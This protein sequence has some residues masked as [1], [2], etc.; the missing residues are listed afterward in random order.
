MSPDRQRFGVVSEL[1]TKDTKAHE[2]AVLLTSCSVVPFVVIEFRAPPS[3][4]AR[5]TGLSPDSYTLRTPRIPSEGT[6]MFK[7]MTPKLMT[8]K[9]KTPKPVMFKRDPF[10]AVLIAF[11]I[12]MFSSLALAQ[13]DS[14]SHQP[15]LTPQASGTTQLLI[16]VSPVD[17]RVIWAAGA[18]GTYTVTTDGGAHWK[19]AVVPGADQLQF[20]DVY[21]VSDKIAY[22]MSVGNDTNNFQI[23]KTF[24]GGA[25]WKVEFTNQLANAFY[26]CFAFWSPDR[27]VTHSDSVNGVFPDIRTFNGLNWHSIANQMPPALSGEASFAASGTCIT[28]EGD[29]NAWITTGGASVARILATRDGGDTWNAYDTPLVS[30]D[31]AGGVSVAF[32]DPW[33]GIVGGGDLSTNKSADAATSDDGGVTW[34]LTKKPPVAGAIFCLAY[35]R[36]NR[37][38]FG[39]DFDNGGWEHEFDRTVV[40]TAE[41]EP[42]FDSG[43]AA[44]TPDEGQTWFKLP[45]VSGYWAVGFADPHDGWFV[46]N[47]GQILKISFDGR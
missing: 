32:R 19:S 25:H 38:Q 28:T 34:T 2:E 36:G 37:H 22:L 14:K 16:A 26:D 15:T 3:E 41:T 1:T 13:D 46:G 9:L 17:S 11:L 35:A 12:C 45:N 24:D 21:A 18:G 7:L 20:R 40:I 27:G 10:I 47:N 6:P 39:W 23:Y 8:P 42:N 43:S 4:L 33:H 5:L 31:S 30:N 29:R 44:W